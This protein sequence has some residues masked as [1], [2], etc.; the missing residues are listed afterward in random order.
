MD[1]WNGP[2]D[3]ELLSKARRAI[4][5]F[6]VRCN[7][8]V[9]VAQMFNLLVRKSDLDEQS[10]QLLSSYGHVIP[11]LKSVIMSIEMWTFDNIKAAFK[12][13]ASVSGLKDSIVMQCLRAFIMG[14]FA[15]P[16]IYQMMEILGKDNSIK[17]IDE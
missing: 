7:T 15:S 13:F 1:F 14:T 6:K 11:Q 8:L 9:E 4:G 5:L 17:R 2:R 10:R 16:G 12:S 3:V